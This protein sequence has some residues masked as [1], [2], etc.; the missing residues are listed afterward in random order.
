M[1]QMNHM[2]HTKKIGKTTKKTGVLAVLLGSIL[3][4]TVVWASTTAGSES[5]PLITKS[6]MDQYVTPQ[7]E[8]DVTEEMLAQ[9]DEMTASL[10]EELQALQEELNGTFQSNQEKFQLVTLSNGQSVVLELGAQVVLRVGSVYVTGS[11]SPA[12]VNLTSGNTIESEST[13]TTNHLYLSTIEG[14]TLTSS[15][16]TTKILVF[17]GYSLG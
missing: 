15:S 16:A 4:S 17:G 1:N 8:A 3:L 10:Q 9:L 6:Y 2:K 12:L 11:Y 7:L 14:R 13:L 5:D